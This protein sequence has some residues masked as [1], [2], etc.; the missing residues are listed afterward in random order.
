MA[1]PGVRNEFVDG[2][3]ICTAAV[4]YLKR[5]DLDGSP[6]L[7]GSDGRQCEIRLLEGNM[8]SPTAR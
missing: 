5:R 8:T 6:K 2:F 4:L 3:D 1:D 7:S